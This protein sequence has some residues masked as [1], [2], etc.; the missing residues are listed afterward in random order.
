MELPTIALRAPNGMSSATGGGL[1][2][3]NAWRLVTS[4]LV[5]RRN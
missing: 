3:R 4:A 2:A 1:T 5:T